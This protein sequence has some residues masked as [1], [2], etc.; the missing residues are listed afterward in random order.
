MF[1]V[2]YF[3]PLQLNLQGIKHQSFCEV[4]SGRCS[5]SDISLQVPFLLSN[6][7]W[8]ATMLSKHHPS[9]WPHDHHLQIDQLALSFLLSPRDLS[10]LIF[11]LQ[12]EPPNL[13]LS[14]LV[15]L[16]PTL[17]VQSVTLSATLWLLPTETSET[18]LQCLQHGMTGEMDFSVQNPSRTFLYRYQFWLIWYV[19]YNAV[20][21]TNMV[22]LKHF[23]SSLAAHAILKLES[24]MQRSHQIV[25]MSLYMKLNSN[26]QGS[27]DCQTKQCINQYKGNP[28]KIQYIRIVWFPPIW[29]I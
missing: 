14:S 5:L 17:Q 4:G 3:T 8:T 7:W 11:L 10:I 2:N 22:H 13:S 9:V 19:W 29:A 18:I 1:R 25:S 28:S 16:P 6:E 26:Q 21:F 23:G 15:L 24:T 20:H 27:L 12:I